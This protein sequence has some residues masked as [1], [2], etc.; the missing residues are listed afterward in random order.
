ME[1]RSIMSSP[2]FIFPSQLCN[3]DWIPPQFL[4]RGG[5]MRLVMVAVLEVRGKT[6]CGPDLSGVLQSNTLPGWCNSATFRPLQEASG[7]V[8]FCILTPN[9]G[10]RYILYM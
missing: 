7:P 6:V 8:Q 5:N 3:Y 1:S 9:K 10:A 4:G 2:L